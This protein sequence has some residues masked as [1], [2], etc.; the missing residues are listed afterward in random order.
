[1]KQ[2]Y[3][4]VLNRTVTTLI[5][6]LVF[7]LPV[8]F[9]PVTTEF[10]EFNKLALTSGVTLAIL[11]LWALKMII[12][13]KVEIVKAPVNIP[14]ILLLVAYGAST[15][16]SIDKYSSLMGSYGRWGGSL[17]LTILLTLLYFAVSSNIKTKEDV[18]RTMFAFI[19]GASISSLIVTLTF[20]G[21]KLGGAGFLQI[22]NFTLTGSSTLAS[23]VAALASVTAL[24]MLFD[25]QN[26][27]ARILL[28]TLALLNFLPVTFVG[29]FS[30]WVLFVVSLA[31]LMVFTSAE[32]IRASNRLLGIVFGVMVLFG[33]LFSI[34]GL[35]SALRLPTDYPKELKLGLRPSWIITSS[36]LR[37]FPIQ[38]SG[39]STFYLNFSHYRPLG[40]NASD[41]W[42]VR[43]DKP[44]NE[45]LEV[46]ATLGIAGLLI[47]VLFAVKTLKL[48]RNT[49][50]SG[51]NAALSAGVVGI[52]V[53]FLFSHSYV[54]LS[55]LLYLFIGLLVS[56]MQALDSNSLAANMLVE[57]AIISFAISGSQ[58]NVTTKTVSIIF[59]VPLMLVAVAGAYFTGRTYAGEVMM[60]RAIQAA[61]TN[62]AQALFANQ[63]AAIRLNPYIGAYHASF[64]QTNFLVANA[65]AA[66]KKQ[67]EL[68]DQDRRNI[69]TLIGAAIQETRVTTELLSKTNPA[70]WEQRG[71]LYSLLTGV[72]KDADTWSTASY[73]RAIEL[74]PTNPILRVSLG[75]V[76]F[77]AKNFDQ[78][79]RHFRA[80]T[81]LK[82]DY[83]NAHY[84]LAQALKANKKYVDA[85]TEMQIV[86]RLIPQDGE[87]AK[88]ANDELAALKAMPEVAG[89]Q[90]NKPSVNDIQGNGGKP[91]KQENLTNPATRPNPSITEATASLKPAGQ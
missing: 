54:L 45:L 32:R 37:D 9:L 78:A 59:A 67:E 65:L 3:L 48:V 57:S 89:A 31:A 60:R 15:Y 5:T 91:T 68:T 76:F 40:L 90:D 30:S 47:F 80:A 24:G 12:E 33:V 72:A 8:F 82:P 28:S 22:R 13:G 55:V 77:T 27:K 85:V 51:V 26:K 21:L 23:A 50:T 64:A 16:F 46:T 71:R 11:A 6:A 25:T 10:F 41:T 66:S 49:D 7:L 81:S 44:F 87:D 29:V 74:D 73:T 38:G 84:N 53:F 61:Q 86:L 79:E 62:G 56:Y 58:T 69:Q 36:S 63:R 17:F 83:A 34:P 4:P 88:R 43:F 52:L 2:K 14:M 35:K 20:F 42:N 70:N 19:L 39:P 18:K 75:G 1:M